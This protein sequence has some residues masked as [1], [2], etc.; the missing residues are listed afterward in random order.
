MRKNWFCFGRVYE[1]NSNF[2]LITQSGGY[3]VN[4]I[5]NIWFYNNCNKFS[6]Y[7]L[8]YCIYECTDISS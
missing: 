7:N 2:K 1:R 4:K 3:I 5:R 8:F 6:E